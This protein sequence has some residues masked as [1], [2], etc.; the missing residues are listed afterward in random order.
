MHAA[1]LLGYPEI[2]V[3]FSKISFFDSNLSLL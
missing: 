1:L 3:I 2:M